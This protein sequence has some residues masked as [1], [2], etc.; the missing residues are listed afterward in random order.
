MIGTLEYT[1]CSDAYTGKTCPNARRGGWCNDHIL[2]QPECYHCLHWRQVDYS[3]TIHGQLPTGCGCCGLY[4][5]SP[6]TWCFTGW[7]HVR[8][9][10]IDC[11]A[12]DTIGC[13][14]CQRQHLKTDGGD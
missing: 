11:G 14:E 4:I 7:S 5:H 6:L 2:T 1:R 12:I 8:D 3:C 10:G 9:W 13:E